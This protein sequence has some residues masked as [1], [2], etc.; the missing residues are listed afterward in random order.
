MVGMERGGRAARAELLDFEK[1]MFKGI[2]L[3]SPC[4]FPYVTALLRGVKA[5]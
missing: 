5:C 4:E 3:H 2:T 1:I